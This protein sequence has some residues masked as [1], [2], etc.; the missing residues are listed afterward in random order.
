MQS[1]ILCMNTS[2]SKN[3]TF[4][5]S[6]L[7]L[8]SIVRYILP[9]TDIDSVDTSHV[10]CMCCWWSSSLFFSNRRNRLLCGIVQIVGT[11]QG[12]SR[13]LQNLFSLF[14]ILPAA[15]VILRINLPLLFFQ[16]SLYSCVELC[17]FASPTAI[18]KKRVCNTCSNTNT[19]TF[20]YNNHHSIETTCSGFTITIY[21][22]KE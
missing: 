2:I 6:R 14:D 11:D 1:R 3:I 5:S 10:C 15:P 16:S 12:Q 17:V 21:H 19:N 22:K 8:S 20:R 18:T 9:S 4:Y 13:I 7:F